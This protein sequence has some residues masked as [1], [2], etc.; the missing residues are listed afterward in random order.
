MLKWEISFLRNVSENVVFYS[1]FSAKD[2]NII[3]EE[4]VF[5]ILHGLCSLRYMLS[6]EAICLKTDKAYK[7][8]P[9]VGHSRYTD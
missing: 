2:Y 3:L 4:T 9:E 8:N 6:Y 5:L 7:I 1:T